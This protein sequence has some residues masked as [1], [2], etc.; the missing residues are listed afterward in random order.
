VVRPSFIVKS[1]GGSRLRKKR[2]TEK[3]SIPVFDL[4]K[5]VEELKLPRSTSDPMLSEKWV[6]K[7]GK[8]GEGDGE[9]SSLKRNVC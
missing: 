9:G 4:T 2:K 3:G 5:N 1:I 7:G 6:K 8:K